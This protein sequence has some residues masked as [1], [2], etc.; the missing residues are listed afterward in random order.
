MRAFFF[1]KTVFFVILFVH[2]PKNS[3][4]CAQ[5]DRCNPSANIPCILLKHVSKYLF[6]KGFAGLLCLLCLLCFSACEPVNKEA[7]DGLNSISYGFHYKNLD[8]TEVYARRALSLAGGYG[9]GRAEAYNNLA[10]VCI[11]KMKYH[12]AYLLLDSVR[13]VTDNQVELLVAD[14]QQMRLCQRES[15][16]KD[17]YD[18]YENAMR[19][20]RRIDEER[21]LLSPRLQRRRDYAESEFYVVASTYYYY[22]GLEEQSSETLRQINEDLVESD[23]AQYLN[24]LYQIGSGGILIDGTEEDIFQREWEHLIRC[25]RISSL[26]GDVFWQANA[27]Q[28]LSE[29]LFVKEARDSL[30]ARN[31]VSMVMLGGCARLVHCR[32]P[33]GAFSGPF[34]AIW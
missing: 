18:Y 27:L 34:P 1:V 31:Q 10:F 17:F 19:T 13:H 16:N 12:E 30:I 4:V 3:G 2:L 28:G 29:H 26:S 32:L 5:I 8:S 11:M 14:V 23:T 20:L 33:G 15:H 22:V 24:Y 9:A 25:Y 6:A 21:N 7:V